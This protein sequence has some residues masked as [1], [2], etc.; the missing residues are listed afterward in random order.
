MPASTLL[1]PRSARR[2]TLPVNQH[3]QDGAGIVV[4]RTKRKRESQLVTDLRAAIEASGK[5]HNA[6]GELAEVDASTVHRFMNGGGL[7][8]ENAGRIAEALGL[9]LRK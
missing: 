8:L 7:T 9:R 5:S 6:I 3:S 2:D 1:S 4:K